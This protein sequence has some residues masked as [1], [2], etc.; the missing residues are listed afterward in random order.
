MRNIFRLFLGLVMA[1]VLYSCSDRLDDYYTAEELAGM[2]IHLQLPNYSKNLVKT[3]ADASSTEEIT[4]AIVIYYGKDGDKT[5]V[6]GQDQITSDKITSSTSGTE[7]DY[8]FTPTYPSGTSSIAVVTNTAALTEDQCKNLSSQTISS[9]PVANKPVCWGTASVSDLLAGNSLSL[10]RMTAKVT[11][12]VARG[13]SSK[14]TVKGIKVYNTADKGYI[15]TTDTESPNVTG[16]NSFATS[17]GDLVNINTLSTSQVFYETPSTADFYV[18]VKGRYTDSSRDGYYKLKLYEDN[19]STQRNLIRNHNYIV[20]ITDVDGGG[21]ATE[22]EAANNAVENGI[23]T[24]VID[25]NPPIVSI[26]ACREYELGVCDTRTFNGT[27]AAIN[28]AG[29]TKDDQG[30]AVTQNITV[31]TSYKINDKFEYSISPSPSDTWIH[32]DKDNATPTYFQSD[33]SAGPESNRGA[34]FVIPVTLDANTTQTSRKGTV[35]VTSGDLTRTITITQEGYDYLGDDAHKVEFFINGVKQSDDYFGDFLANQVYGVKAADN[36]GM[37]RDHVLHFPAVSGGDETYSYLI[38]KLDGDVINNEHTDLFTVTSTTKDGNNY[39]EVTLTN[40]AKA[41]DNLWK[42]SFTN[43]TKINDK[44]VA[45]TY[46]VYHTGVFHHIT[47]TDNQLGT[48][49]TGWFYYGV[50]EVKGTS[51]STYHL[52]DRNIGATNNGFYSP[53]TQETMGNEGAKGAYM[54]L[55]K[56]KHTENGVVSDDNGITIYCKASTAPHLYVWNGSTKLNG[57]WPGKV[58]SETMT[59]GGTTYYYQTFNESPI[60]IIFNNGNDKQKTGDIEN[61]TASSFYSYNNNT[62]YKKLDIIFPDVP[63]IGDSYMPFSSYFKVPTE[64]YVDDILPKVEKR[65]TKT[66]EVYYCYVIKT[67]KDVPST[68]QPAE[69]YIPV[70][71]YYEG[72]SYRN[73]NHANI[74]T[75]TRLSGY[76]G[77]SSSSPEF[78]FWFRYLDCHNS[79]EEITN[80]R[81]V[82]GSAGHSGSIYN[83]LPVRGIHKK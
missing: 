4:S 26:I 35:T 83:A 54:I 28:A 36:Q 7:T 69:V 5:T 44:T 81:I 74:W 58:M 59:I 61:I 62:D 51:G 43:T 34:K 60:N 32:I 67:S 77:F 72:T 8:S 76:Q 42:Y 33:G 68:V 19:S 23:S 63:N 6:I 65:P 46:P 15:T 64:S 27:G 1:T 31:A 17:V 78:G 25:D 16:I 40:S 29:N 2:K 75:C 24:T 18:I 66:G 48:A 55:T 39:W 22:T 10:F 73:E 13:I 11:V 21:Y 82:N 56:D 47:S 53:S 52:L 12:Q 38:P 3:R 70:T 49:K 9:T 57:D 20:T 30:K 14:F 71:G 80:M 50:V 41:S 79:I 45:V 37:A